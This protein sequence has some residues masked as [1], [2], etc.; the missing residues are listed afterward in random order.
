MMGQGELQRVPPRSRFGQLGEGRPW[1]VLAGGG[2]AGV[3]QQEGGQEAGRGLRATQD[4]SAFYTILPPAGL[5]WM[6]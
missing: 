3:D 4:K 2:E 1:A 6:V 5:E